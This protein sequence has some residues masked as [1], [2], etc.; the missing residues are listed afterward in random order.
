MKYY[1]YR[2]FDTPVTICEDNNVL[3]R[4]VFGDN[5]YPD[6]SKEQNSFLDNVAI[7]LRKLDYLALSKIPTIEI[8]SIKAT[9]F[10]KTVWKTLREIPLGHTWTYK[11]IATLLTSSPRAVGNAVGKNPLMI[12]VPCHRVI[13]SDGSLGG[14]AGGIKLKETLLEIEK[15]QETNS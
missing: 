6:G 5:Y 3:S 4:I 8:D 14:Y 13:C 10:Q 11:Q 7:C 2:I 12:M 15:R 1:V 9:D